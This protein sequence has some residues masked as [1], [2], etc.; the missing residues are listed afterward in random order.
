MVMSVRHASTTSTVLKGCLLLIFSLLTLTYSLII[1]SLTKNTQE[2]EDDA[3]QH[4]ATVMGHLLGGLSESPR[5]LLVVGELPLGT[6]AYYARCVEH[7]GFAV[8]S[9]LDSEVTLEMCESHAMMLISASVMYPI[10]LPPNLRACTA[11]AIIWDD[12]VYSTFGMAGEKLF[13]DFGSA[14][15]VY[16]AQGWAGTL[17]NPSSIRLT[18]DGV[19]II[20]AANRAAAADL[21]AGALSTVVGRESADLQIV[22]FYTKPWPM[23]WAATRGAGARVVA[24]ME[25]DESKAVFFWYLEGGLLVDGAAAPAMRIALPMYH[26]PHGDVPY[27]GALECTTG[28]SKFWDDLLPKKLSSCL[29]DPP[30]AEEQEPPF[31]PAGKALVDLAIQL[32]AAP[33]FWRLQRQRYDWMLTHPLNSSSLLGTLLDSVSF[34][35]A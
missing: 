29:Q 15:D 34:G 28:E 19:N 35:N 25:G 21:Q 22:P 12:A 11:P 6:D 17:P 24:H 13:S 18:R 14:A 8:D 20:H 16:L 4:V 33:A 30:P 23:S 32:A 2:E 26:F 1:I 27:R 5:A 7:A 9:V 31:A 10:L 3:K